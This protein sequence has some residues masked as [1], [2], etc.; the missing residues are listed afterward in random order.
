MNKEKRIKQI[1]RTLKPYVNGKLITP[2]FAKYF[3]ELEELLL[4]QEI[5]IGEFWDIEM[6]ERIGFFDTQFKAFIACL[7]DYKYRRDSM[8]PYYKKDK[9]DNKWHIYDLIKDLRR[10]SIYQIEIR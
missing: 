6:Y 1:F 2:V 9:V 10:Y 3:K 5:W 4:K 8:M 7:K